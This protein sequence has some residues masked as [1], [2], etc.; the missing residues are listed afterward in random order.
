[1]PPAHLF[2]TTLADKANKQPI[3]CMSVRLNLLSGKLECTGQLEK[4]TQS[5]KNRN[6]SLFY[7]LELY[8]DIQT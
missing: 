3:N 6:I 2:P 1:M 5:K 7:D 4:C 8:I